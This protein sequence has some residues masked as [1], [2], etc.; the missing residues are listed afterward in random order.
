MEQYLKFIS[1]QQYGDYLTNKFNAT[2]ER[3]K[4]KDHFFSRIKPFI[5]TMTKEEKEKYS[6]LRDEEK[7]EELDKFV[8]SIESKKQSTPQMIDEAIQE[9]E[10][11]TKKKGKREKKPV[12]TSFE[13]HDYHKGPW[14]KIELI[15]FYKKHGYVPPLQN[16]KPRK[17]NINKL[18]EEQ[19]KKIKKTT[20]VSKLGKLSIQFPG[21][22]R[23]HTGTWKPQEMYDYYKEWGV[24]PPTK[25]GKERAITLIDLEYKIKGIK[26]PKTQG[27][28][29][30]KATVV[31]KKEEPKMTEEPVRDLRKLRAMIT[32]LY[33]DLRSE[34]TE[35]EKMR[36]TRLFKEQHFDDVY[37]FMKQ[38]EKKY[39]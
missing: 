6:K 32:E 15:E 21:P 4:L 20:Q 24:I 31:K 37:K 10:Q 16:G 33:D 12:K 26:R 7:F 19:E 14:S 34:M 3:I 8:K 38:M 23:K 35:D 22:W 1:S 9:V 11:V 27:L 25:Q 17:T 36:Y 30:T 2:T 29:T 39:Y 13:P 28:M 18:I 5:Q